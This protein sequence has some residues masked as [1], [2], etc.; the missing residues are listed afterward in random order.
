M[1][2][3]NKSMQTQYYSVKMYTIFRDS[4]QIKL[5]RK[6][7]SDKLK[8]NLPSDGVATLS[9]HSVSFL[10]YSFEELKHTN[11]LHAAHNI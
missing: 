3:T 4:F 2:F 1:L 10:S 11:F 8:F 9:T 5:L 6:Q 7:I